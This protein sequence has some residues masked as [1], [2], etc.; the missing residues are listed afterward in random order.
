MSLVLLFFDQ[1]NMTIKTNK[2]IT[3]TTVVIIAQVLRD[4]LILSFENSTQRIMDAIN[5]NMKNIPITITVP[6]IF[7]LSDLNFR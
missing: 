1:T 3:S 6:V 5:S 7:I 2:S 4:L